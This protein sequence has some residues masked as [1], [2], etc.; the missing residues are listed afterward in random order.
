MCSLAVQIGEQVDYLRFLPEKTVANK[1]AWWC[2]VVLAGPGWVIIG[3]LKI[4]AG[5]LLVRP[6]PF[7]RGDAPSSA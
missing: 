4:L 1:K 2:A 3:G 7:G 5:S 6:R